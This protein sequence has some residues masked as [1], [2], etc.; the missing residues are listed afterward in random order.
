MNLLIIDNNIDRHCWG[1]AD[2]RRF[3]RLSPGAIVQ[4][5]RAPQ[6]DLPTDL[7]RFD[8]VILSGSKTSCLA[9]APWI[10]HLLDWTRAWLATRKPFLG[11][12][13]GHQTLVRAL[14]GK[15]AVRKGARAELGWTRLHRRGASRLLHGLPDEFFSFSSHYEEVGQAPAGFQVTAHSADCAIQAIELPDQPVFGIQF[16]PEKDLAD[17]AQLR[18]DLQRE[19]DPRVFMDA[20]RGEQRFDPAVGD[21]IFGNFLKS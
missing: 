1:S 5:R 9:D 10:D 13:Y 4:T 16:H 21:T 12:C 15:P 20:A 2:L 6:G 14:G 18:R 3:A 19:R 11:V 17:A 7:S 8:R